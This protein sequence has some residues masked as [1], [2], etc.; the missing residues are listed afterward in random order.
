MQSAGSPSHSTWTDTS[1]PSALRC[2]AQ[3]SAVLRLPWRVPARAGVTITA[4]MPVAPSF[5]ENLLREK[6]G[7]TIANAAHRAGWPDFAQFRPHAT[8]AT[9]I[10]ALAEATARTCELFSVIDRARLAVPLMP[11]V[12]PPLWELGH[13]A[14]FYEFWIDRRGDVRRPSRIAH[15]DALY[16][17]AKVAHD[18]RWQLALPDIAATWRYLDEMMA[19][20]GDALSHGEPDD[21]L[22]YFVTLGLLHH[23]MHNEAFTY[24]WHTLGYPDSRACATCR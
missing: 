7:A 5:A 19:F 6:S 4:F 20:A 18:S 10:G 11:I 24:M 9:L 17:S 1:W 13:V 22:A 21:E 3:R 15:A 23:D 14:Y 8:A 16:D 12:N 2:A